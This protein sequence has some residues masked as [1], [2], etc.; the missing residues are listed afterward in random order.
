MSAADNYNL[1][2][3][4]H[5]ETSVPS[6]PSPSEDDTASGSGDDDSADDDDVR[7]DL[8]KQY[9]VIAYLQTRRSTDLGWVTPRQIE[10][11]T[12]VDLPSDDA[13]VALL[14]ASNP[15]VRTETL[16]DGTVVYGYQ[17]KFNVSDRSGLLAQINRC[18]NGVAAKEL[19][20][21]YDG[22][23]GDLDDM[24]V[25]GEIIAVQNKES[26]DRT[27]FPR[28]EPFF[29]ELSGIV[30][31]GD[32]KCSIVCRGGDPDYTKEIRRGEAVWTSGQWFRASSAVKEGPLSDQPSRAQAPP[33]VSSN[34]PLPKKNELEGYLR[35][36][37]ARTVPLDRPL[38]EQTLQNA[39]EADA[40]LSAHGGAA[41]ALLLNP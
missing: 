39:A 7:S 14:L 12:R 27:L 8:E 31:L 6:G 29:V 20:D 25:G 26:C 28:G 36:M 4:N 3:L 30:K 9:E 18:R 34:A 32:E 5:T 13:P 17:A 21:T 35:P 11:A 22:V 37:D 41:A 23:A 38:H 2:F 10:S 19:G 24:I 1:Q 40:A 15:K 33:S 16:A